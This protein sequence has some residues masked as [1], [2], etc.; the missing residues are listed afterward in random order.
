M[1]KPTP[2]VLQTTGPMYVRSA[3]NAKKLLGTSNQIMN[4]IS[5]LHRVNAAGNELEFLDIFIKMISSYLHKYIRSKIKRNKH[6]SDLRFW[7][8]FS[9]VWFKTVFQRG[10][11]NL[12][13]NIQH[14][15]TEKEWNRPNST[16]RNFS[17]SSSALHSENHQCSFWVQ[18]K[19][20]VETWAQTMNPMLIH[21]DVQRNLPHRSM[22]PLPCPIVIDTTLY[23]DIPEGCVLVGH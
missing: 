10:P 13:D 7:P 21:A 8:P 2:T 9:P 17:L 4:I 3:K 11:K 20:R 23:S 16:T 12:Q 5:N 19:K 6:S 14:G 1:Q 22:V 18:W 15:G